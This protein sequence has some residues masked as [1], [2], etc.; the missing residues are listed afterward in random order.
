M[1]YR[2]KWYSQDG[3]DCSRSFFFGP[4]QPLLTGSIVAMGEMFFMSKTF[5]P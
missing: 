5:V 1:T 3:A 4:R 2:H